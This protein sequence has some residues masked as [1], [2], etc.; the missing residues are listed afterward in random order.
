MRGHLADALAVEQ[1]TSWLGLLHEVAQVLSPSIIV[2]A[3]V[4][5]FGSTT[6]SD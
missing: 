3:V 5:V 4:K 1:G 2:L 6:A